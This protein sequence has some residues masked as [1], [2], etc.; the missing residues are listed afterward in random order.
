MQRFDDTLDFMA[1]MQGA[2][3]SEEVTT[4]LTQL[5]G[6]RYGLNAVLAGLPTLDPNASGD[7]LR[8][9]TLLDTWPGP[10]LDRYISQGYLDKD[11]LLSHLRIDP[12][13]VR[14]TTVFAKEHA[15]SV[16]MRILGEASEFGLKQGMGLAFRTLEG[17]P[18]VISL[19]GESIDVSPE[20]FGTISMV[21]AFAIGR[22]LE[23][24]FGKTDAAQHRPLSDREIECIRWAARGKSEWEISQILGISEHTSE[25]HLLR[26]K[27]KLGAI[28]R[29]HAVAEAIRQGYIS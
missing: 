17:V 10:W 20:D 13:P 28:N 25:K 24:R 6:R 12:G 26:A 21:C 16:G 2:R 18:V 8:E 19:G 9:L 3:T 23:I 14:W 7:N 11:P 27:A 29:V 5:T 15:G 4:A 1:R 22:A